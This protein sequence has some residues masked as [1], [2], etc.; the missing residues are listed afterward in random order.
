L[1]D[2]V[3]ALFTWYGTFDSDRVESAGSLTTVEIRP[4]LSE[5]ADQFVGVEASSLE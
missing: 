5:N 2:L 1:R 3:I 4:K